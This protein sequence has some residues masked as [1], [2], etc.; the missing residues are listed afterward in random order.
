MSAIHQV[1]VIVPNHL[2]DEDARLAAV[3]EMLSM[4]PDAMLVEGQPVVER[5]NE[6]IVVFTT[7]T[8]AIYDTALRIA[9]AAVTN[10]MESL[11]ANLESNPL[12]TQDLAREY[13]IV[14]QA[15]VDRIRETFHNEEEN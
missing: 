4:Y 2:T 5:E 1:A 8:S 9:V 15:L 10:E 14:C 6:S 13:A 11:V 7:F 3:D 12:L